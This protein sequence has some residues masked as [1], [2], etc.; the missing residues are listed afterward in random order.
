MKEN[1]Q[2]FG[3][4]K[5]SEQN[6]KLKLEINGVTIPNICGYRLLVDPQDPLVIKVSIDMEFFR[7]DVQGEI[8]FIPYC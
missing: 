5:F 6:G 8:K 3:E 4:V 2:N 7:S 1:N